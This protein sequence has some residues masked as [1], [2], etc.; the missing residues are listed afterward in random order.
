MYDKP[1][2]IHDKLRQPIQPISSSLIQNTGQHIIDYI[3]QNGNIPKKMM[4]QLSSNTKNKQ[5]KISIATFKRII[6]KIDEINYKNKENETEIESLQNRIIAL[7][8]NQMNSNDTYD[9]RS[10]Y[11]HKNNPMDICI[12]PAPSNLFNL[13]NIEYFQAESVFNL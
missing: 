9:D 2:E 12:S 4:D 6:N 8:T 1:K 5:I 10:V 7:E 3:F 11:Y 13:R